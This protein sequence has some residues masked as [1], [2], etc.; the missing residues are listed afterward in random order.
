MKKVI[1]IIVGIVLLVIIGVLSIK[2]FDINEEIYFLQGAKQT[3][4]TGAVLYDL[5]NTPEKRGYDKKIWI[6]NDVLYVKTCCM[7]STTFASLKSV[8]VL[9]K[10]VEEILAEHYEEIDGEYYDAENN[11]TIH[12]YSIEEGKI[13]NYIIYTY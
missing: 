4:E 10:E 5:S 6:P 9:K 8:D 13:M 2:L 7:Y 11:F 3:E 12:E 1:L